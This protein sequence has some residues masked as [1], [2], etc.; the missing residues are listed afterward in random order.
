MNLSVFEFFPWGWFLVSVPCGRR[1]CLI[2]FQ[3]SWFSWGLFCVSSY[4]LS[5][6]I[7]HV[8][9]KRMCILL[10]WDE[11][12]YMSVNSI[13]SRTLHNAAISLLIFCLEDLSM[14]DSGVIII[15]LLTKSF[16]KSSKI[17]FMF[18]GAP[19]SVSYTH[20]TLPTTLVKCRSRWSP[21][22]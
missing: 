6:K 21:Y 16:L 1:K 3:F 8:H 14:F 10:L 5:L 13:L 9:L 20:L 22:H 2:W 19:M 11:R 18:L 17:F 15:V 12:F 7:F 4:G